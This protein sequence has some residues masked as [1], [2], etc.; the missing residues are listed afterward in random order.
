MSAKKNKKERLTSQELSG[1]CAQVAMMMSSGMPLY[2]GMEAM[3]RTYAGTPQADLFTRISTEVTMSGSL[4]SALKKE[5]VFPAYLTEMTGIGERTGRTEEI[6][7]SLSNYYAREGRIRSAI[8]SAVTYPMLLAIMMALIVVVLIWK[9]MPVFRRVLGSMGVTLT[10][11]GNTLMNLGTTI[12]W[13]V[14]GLVVILAAAS[15]VFAL[16]MRTGKRDAALGFLLKIFRPAARLRRDLSASRVSSVLSMMLGS[17]FPL[18]EALELVPGIL[19][20]PLAAEEVRKIRE[21]MGGG[22]SF[23]QALTSGELFDPLYSSMIRTGC[24]VGCADQVMSR[25]AA[26]YE[27]RVEDGIAG[28]VSVIEPVIVGT[29][30]VV[31]GCILL[32]VMLPMTGIIASMM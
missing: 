4:Y 2:D 6:M 13:V 8:R 20:D 7:N 19:G 30:S 32:S 3:A 9:V 27:E 10:A 29:L 25:V 21:Q 5:K 12:A 17:G 15:V 16:L 11:S 18:D 22:V 23:G 1:F 26:G 31:I 24:D 28:L 14:L